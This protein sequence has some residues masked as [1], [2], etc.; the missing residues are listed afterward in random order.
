MK[1][2]LK[3]L[4]FPSTE[5]TCL[6]NITDDVRKAVS[7]SKVKNGL[8]VIN[9][10]HTTMGV[11]V[12]EICE[13][14]LVKDFVEY[15]LKNTPTDTRAHKA[16]KDF[17][18]PTGD[19]CHRCQDNPLC[20]EIDLEYDAASHIRSMLYTQPTVSIPIHDGKLALGKYQE[21]GAFEF[22]GRD[23]TGVNPIRQRTIQVWIYPFEEVVKL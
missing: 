5:Y 1:T 9:S 11:L 2:F 3:E 10:R 4:K 18:Y 21:I 14:N 20:D 13:P 6:N 7:K 16:Q 8:V 12:Q 17:C 23:G 22:D 19:F 15:A